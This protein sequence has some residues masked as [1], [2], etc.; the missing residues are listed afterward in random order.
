MPSYYDRA[1]AYARRVVSREETAGRFE[2]L[3]CERFLADLERQGTPDFPYVL[4]DAAP[5]A[6]KRSR[7]ARACEF[8]ELLPHIKGQWAR[9]EYRDG[10]LQYTKLKLED[11]QVF[12][13]LNV[14]GWLHRETGLRRF[15]RVYEEVAR[16]NA[17]ST[18]AAGLLLFCLAADA[19]PGA[20]VFS[21]AT[22]GDQARLVFD[23]ARQMALREPEFVARFGVSVAMHDIT[24]P[25]TASS[26][27]PL[28]AEGSTLDGLNIHAAIVDELHAHKTR[29]VYDVLDTATGA[30]SQ[31]LIVMITT[32]GSDRSGICYEQRDY[33]VKVLERT[34]VDE[35]WFG[36]VYTLDDGDLWHDPA[37]WRKAN[38]NFGVSVLPDDMQAACRKAQAQ[39]SALNNFLTKRLNV[40]VNA[41]SAWMDMRA[42][43]KAGDKT[44]RVARV[45]QLPCVSALDLASKV[46]VAAQVL[47]FHDD[48]ADHYYLIP[49]FWLPRRAI[50]QGRNSQ[51][52]GW[53]RA[54]HLQ[55]TDGEVIDFDQIEDALRNDM[56][57]LNVTE[58]P[59]DP[60]QATQLASHMLSEGA[61][62]VEYRQTVQNMSEP[63]KLFESLVLQGKLTHDGNPMMT[64]MVSNVVCHRDVKD[65]IYP[66]KERDEN[67]IDGPV[68]AIMAIGRI[69]ANQPPESDSIEQGF[70][71]L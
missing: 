31:P 18:L 7:G 65:N 51:Y 71:S 66:R 25:G 45:A 57:E 17:K 27:K 21:A 14:F 11:W 37:T 2:R 6:G 22:T 29:A 9:P 56:V 24:V 55:V 40:W 38:P 12:I 10:R 47:L 49:R 62:M 8:L 13:V 39:P 68:A 35:N 53:A 44:L 60:W 61:P 70:V 23:D 5:T 1:V 46:D 26:A 69:V 59:F 3:A 58:M 28:N 15:R 52:D 30:R 20:Q 16:K 48:Q 4:D 33:T 32:A 54:G 67:K 64:W 36:V 42:W 43:D 34:I 19:E 63:M 41:D 50:D